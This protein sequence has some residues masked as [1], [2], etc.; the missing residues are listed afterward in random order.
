MARRSNYD[1]FPFVPAGLA[2]ECSAGWPA[3][4]ARLGRC[5]QG[6]VLCVECYPGVF[7]GQLCEDLRNQFPSSSVFDSERCLKAQGQ[8][9]AMLDPLLGNDPV[10]G[11][12]SAIELEN[13]FDS[14]KLQQMRIDIERA[15]QVG[16][17]IVVG[18]GASLVAPDNALRVYAD[19]ARWEIQLRWRRN[20]VGNLGLDN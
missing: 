19:L 20:E 8:L 2:S 13:Y 3:I 7:V 16:P 6:R 5:S 14:E 12:M 15:A 4:A 17:A 10:F 1:K 11:R 18:A 9:R